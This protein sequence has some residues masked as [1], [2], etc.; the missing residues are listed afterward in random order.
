MNQQSQWNVTIQK[1]LKTHRSG[2]SKK[3]CPS[4][5]VEESRES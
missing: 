2:E 3:M 4:K 1:V 5:F